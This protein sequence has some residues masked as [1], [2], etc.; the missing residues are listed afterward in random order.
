MNLKLLPRHGGFHTLSP[1]LVLLFKKKMC[2][3][4]V[5]MCLRVSVSVWVTVCR[6][7][8]GTF[9]IVLSLDSLRQ[10]ILTEFGAH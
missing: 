10:G 5:C 8:S 1:L 3:S 4:G 7:Q 6:G 9:F 2:M